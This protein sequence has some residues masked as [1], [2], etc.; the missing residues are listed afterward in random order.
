MVFSV[1]TK[2]VLFCGVFLTSLQKG[3]LLHPKDIL[4]GILGGTGGTR[5]NTYN[6]SK[7]YSKP[8]YPPC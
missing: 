5:K 2:G 8:S 7:P 4:E 6:P 1:C 3:P